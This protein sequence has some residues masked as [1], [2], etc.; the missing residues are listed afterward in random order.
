MAALYFFEADFQLRK[1]LELKVE[2]MHSIFESMMTGCCL[3][4]K[5]TLLAGRCIVEDRLW[6]DPITVYDFS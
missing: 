3:G 5:W 6:R 2:F 1:R 4:I